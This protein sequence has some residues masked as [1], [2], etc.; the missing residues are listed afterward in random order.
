MLLIHYITNTIIYCVNLKYIQHTYQHVYIL[1]SI[2]F[3]NG[4][5][6]AGSW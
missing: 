6:L 4:I 3:E 5:S 1:S 2:N